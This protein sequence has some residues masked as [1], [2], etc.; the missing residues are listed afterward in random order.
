MT[1]FPISFDRWY[2]AL[3]RLLG[4]PPSVAYVDVSAQEVQVRMGWAFNSRF[5]RSAVM[6]VSAP[7]HTPL[8]RGVHGFGGRW[9]VNGSSRQVMTLV[10]NPAQ[11]AYVLGLP[12]SLSELSVSVADAAAVGAALASTNSEKIAR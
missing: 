1:R 9:L 5:P 7:G 8:S 4:L 3:S 11:R 2:R 12:V 6:S 10:L